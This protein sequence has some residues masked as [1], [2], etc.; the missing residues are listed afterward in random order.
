VRTLCCIAV[1]CAA[2]APAEAAAAIRFEIPAGP[3]QGALIRLAEQAGLTI[4]ASDPG[5]ALIRSRG[6]RGRMPA[7]DALK[8]LLAGTGY[9]YRFIAPRAVQIVRVDRTARGRM[10]PPRP[11]PRLPNSV[12]EPPQVEIIVT[13]TKQGVALSR[14]AG[15]AR[16]VDL[17]DE[18]NRFAALGSEA[19]VNRLPILSSTNLGTGRNKIFIR[20]VADSS[21]N[22]PSQST[23]GQYLGDVRLTINAADPN[24]HLSDMQSVEVLEGPQGTLYGTGALGG[25]LRL[26]PRAPRLSQ[27][28]VSG[29]A[30]LIR[31]QHG[32]RGED[33]SAML[34]LP[35]VRDRMAVRAVA[36]Q[37]VD[38]GYIDDLE[39]GL[40]NVNETRI[41][42]GRAALGL[43]LGDGW[44]IGASG[45]VQYIAGR[46]GQYALR[47][48]PALARRSGLEQPF[49]NDYALAYLTLRKSWDG[50]ELVSATGLAN[51]QLE[52]QFD[53]TGFPG[54]S[55]PQ[56]FVEDV[57]IKLV[58]HETRV[59]QPNSRGEGWLVGVSVFHG[60]NRLTRMLGDPEAP[61][62]LTGVRNEASE[63]ALFG[64]YSVAIAPRLTGTIGGR[65][66]YSTSTGMPL[67]VPDEV[68][69]DEPKRDDF[70]ASPTAAMM[71]QAG[72]RVLAY[73]RYQEGFRAGGLAVTPS[74][75][76]V[77]AQ[78]FKSDRI[79]SVEGG[80]RFGR[81][82]LDPLSIEAAVSYLK[83]KNIQA[84][85]IDIQGLP[86]TT[87]IGNGRIYGFEADVHWR[88]LPSLDVEASAFLNSSALV[89]PAP[90]FA[91]AEERD[92][93]NIAS[94]GG[95]VAAR[96]STDLAT[97]VALRIDG[98]VRYVGRSQ[99]GIGTP[100]DIEQGDY[101]VGDIGARLDF[102][103]FGISLDVTNVADTRGNRFSFGNPFTVADRLHVTPV[104]PRTFRIGIDADF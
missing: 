102:G 26:V 38:P 13:A 45:L 9:S 75:T 99:L 87:N 37:S 40:S 66:T 53:A 6:I 31:T 4:D 22:G 42:G 8:R 16:V 100:F 103:R 50:A 52:S 82:G 15:S 10:A 92:L 76:D 32:G 33:L 19:I 58:S 55:D 62:P 88:A 29:S 97:A 18:G 27:L 67:N 80:L 65:L 85:L 104:R 61:A 21:F 95:R 3:L 72:R 23:V 12:P 30:G 1:T 98:A 2:V 11:P 56:L 96:Y 24:L 94:E 7:R 39:R 54:T 28:E 101:A 74:G 41:R 57:H 90:A 51:H 48:F 77:I 84:D 60:V 36:Y 34:N 86:Y 44:E 79:G 68:D 49:D 35:I 78:R 5:L 69:F 93:P 64:Q 71:W 14:F 25:I 89:S 63:A 17:S 73:V 43:D 81:K 46:D 20:G 91:S 83:W 59:S 70:R 47:G